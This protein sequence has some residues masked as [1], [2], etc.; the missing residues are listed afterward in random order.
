MMQEIDSFEEIFEGVRNPLGWIFESP[1]EILKAI[2]VQRYALWHAKGTKG[3]QFIQAWVVEHYED[4]EDDI[5]MY[6]IEAIK[7]V[8]WIL[9]GIM[10]RLTKHVYGTPIYAKRLKVAILGIAIM[11]SS[12]WMQNVHKSMLDK[13]REYKQADK[14]EW[15]TRGLH[16]LEFEVMRCL[17][18]I[19]ITIT[20][21]ILRASLLPEGNQE[22]E[23]TTK[24]MEVEIRLQ[25]YHNALCMYLNVP[26]YTDVSVIQDNEIL[27][28]IE[29]VPTPFWKDNTPDQANKPEPYERGRPKIKA[30]K[31]CFES[32]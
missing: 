4:D 26:N 28:P 15:N 27:L 18:H 8:N 7:R 2:N 10:H 6:P 5:P 22:I 29:C 20:E 9:I 12:T 1:S 32:Q 30:V 17:D 31:D 11:I 13:H 24:S 14:I 23:D 25:T 19:D 16:E 3:Y 21:P